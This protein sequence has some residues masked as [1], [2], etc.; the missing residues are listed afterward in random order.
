MRRTLWTLAAAVACL[1]QSSL[2]AQDDAAAPTR[3]QDPD[4]PAGRVVQDRDALRDRG[5]QQE[6]FSNLTD[7]QFLRLAALSGIMEVS[8]SKLVDGRTDNQ[9]LEQFA[10]KMIDDHNTANA[11]LTRLAES[12]S[13]DIPK[14]LDERHKQMYDRFS[15]MEEGAAFERAYVQ[16]Q[17]RAHQRAVR[18]FAAASE[19]VQDPDIQ[20][21]A[22]KTLPI[23]RHH[24]EMAQGLAGVRPGDAAPATVPDRDR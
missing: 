17:L 5:Q 1:G 15:D 8:V 22:R 23:L 20:A 9:R 11:E 13:I 4:P 12:K 6:D 14:T 21:F 7:E 3:D 10:E 2:F 24:L 16:Q 19:R 18:L